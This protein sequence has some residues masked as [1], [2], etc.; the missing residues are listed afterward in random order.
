MKARELSR[1]PRSRRG[2]VRYAVVGLGHIAQVAALPAFAHARKNSELVALVSGDEEKRS[3]LAR[4]HGVP[5]DG[6]DRR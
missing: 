5:I 4:R 2:K 6:Q 3:A 1:R